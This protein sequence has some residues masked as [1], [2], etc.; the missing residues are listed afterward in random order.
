MLGDV[1]KEAKLGCFTD[2]II[3][4]Q[5]LKEPFSLTMIHLPNGPTMTFRLRSVRTAKSLRVGY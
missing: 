1:L 3:I 2:V 5:R 4:G